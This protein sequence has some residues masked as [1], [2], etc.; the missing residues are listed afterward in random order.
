MIGGA[1]APEQTPPFGKSHTYH[2]LEI[3]GGLTPPLKI[4]KGGSAAFVSG[5]KLEGVC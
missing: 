4:N 3:E 2:N 5:Q 1:R